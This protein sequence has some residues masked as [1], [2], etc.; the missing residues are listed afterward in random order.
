[1][2][3]NDTKDVLLLFFDFETTG[4]VPN[5]NVVTEIGCICQYADEEPFQMLVNEGVRICSVVEKITGISNEMISGQPSMLTAMTM[6]IDWINKLRQKYHPKWVV[7]IAHNNFSFDSIY[8]NQFFLRHK[9]NGLLTVSKKAVYDRNNPDHRIKNL[10][11][12]DW[13]FDSCVWARCM[14]PQS[15]KLQDVANPNSLG[16]LYEAMIGKKIE[17]AHRAL[18]DCL[19]MRELCMCEKFRQ[20]GMTVDTFVQ[21]RPS[22]TYL[23]TS[24]ELYND[25]LRMHRCYAYR[26]KMARAVNKLVSERV[27]CSKITGKRI[28]RKTPV[29]GQKRKLQELES[30]FQTDKKRNK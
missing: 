29:V 20:Y 30:H 19:A 23:R 24:N 4:T 25:C 5:A 13:W 22:Y 7:M 18:S 1:M 21:P 10:C 14:I 16:H 27:V 11:P 3:V 9:L 6:W 26:M 12:I 17:N 15:E 2:N 8:F 28:E